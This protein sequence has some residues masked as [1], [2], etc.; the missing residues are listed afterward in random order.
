MKE[1]APERTLL[2][3]LADAWG[4]ATEYWGFDGNKVMV[5]DLT[6]IRILASL[7]VDASNEPSARRALEEAR[8]RPWRETLP[9]CTVVRDD[10]ESRVAVHSP[11]GRV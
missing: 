2:C 10:R 7:G 5:S 11:T 1:N 3:E 6:L 8:M 9:A 4:V